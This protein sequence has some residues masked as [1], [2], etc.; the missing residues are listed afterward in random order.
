MLHKRAPTL[1]APRKVLRK[2]NTRSCED[3]KGHLVN[4]FRNAKIL[5]HNTLPCPLHDQCI[6]LR[7]GGLVA[8]DQQAR[9]LDLLP[10]VVT[11]HLGPSHSLRM[12]HRHTHQT[13]LHTREIKTK[14]L[15]QPRD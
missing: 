14:L 7:E 6:D 2:E 1:S 8:R 12:T 3:E 13:R 11:E 4:H 5:W 10:R 15:L 9:V